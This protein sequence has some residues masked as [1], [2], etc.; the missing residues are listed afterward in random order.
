MS[1]YVIR[2]VLMIPIL[3]FGISVIDFVFI[4][5]APGDPVT[6]MMNP[7]ERVKMTPRDIE[8]RR[9]AVGGLP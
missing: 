6:A 5:I 3:L 9:A 1:T 4:N 2:R 8:R 7:T